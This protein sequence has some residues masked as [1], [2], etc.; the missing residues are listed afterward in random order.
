MKTEA[1][2]RGKKKFIRTKPLVV[3][4]VPPRLVKKKKLIESPIMT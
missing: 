1:E 4:T 2:K 3:Q